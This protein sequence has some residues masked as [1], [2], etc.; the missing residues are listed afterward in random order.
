MLPKPSQRCTAVE[1]GYVWKANNNAIIDVVYD[2]L[3]K[4]IWSGGFIANALIAHNTDTLA[5]H[6]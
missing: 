4:D 5:P 2:F 6:Q 3:N 1:R